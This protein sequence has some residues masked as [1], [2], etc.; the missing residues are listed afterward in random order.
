MKPD[1]KIVLITDN[2]SGH[3]RALMHFY[4]NIKVAPHTHNTTQLFQKIN[5]DVITAFKAYY[6]E[7]IFTKLIN[8]NNV[9][10][11]AV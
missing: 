4:E 10:S 8:L 2:C 3:P 5:E 6:S 9:E 11:K 1:H 7:T